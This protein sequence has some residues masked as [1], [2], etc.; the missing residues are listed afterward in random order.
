MEESKAGSRLNRRGRVC[1]KE[2]G[3]SEGQRCFP[4]ARF[5]EEVSKREADD[6]KKRNGTS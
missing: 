6:L 1:P 5:Q 4:S 2:R 3:N